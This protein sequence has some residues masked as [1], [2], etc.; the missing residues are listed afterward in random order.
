MM[1]LIQIVGALW[2]VIGVANIVT[3]PPTAGPVGGFVLL[4]NGVLFVIPGLALFALGSMRKKKHATSGPLKTCP[5]CAEAIQQAAIVCK[6]CHKD[7]PPTVPVAAVETPTVSLRLRPIILFGTLAFLVFAALAI[8][9]AFIKGTPI[10][11]D[12]ARG[13]PPG[14]DPAAWASIQNPDPNEP[15][16]S[17]EACAKKVDDYVNAHGGYR[18]NATKLAAARLVGLCMAKNR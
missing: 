11:N 4:F 8:V 16:A 17:D 1:I 12:A 7:L 3:S 2:A 13:T 9:A 6:H 18:D 15:S 14:W 5:F 10:G